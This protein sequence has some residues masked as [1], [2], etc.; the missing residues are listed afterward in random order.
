MKYGASRKVPN[1]AILLLILRAMG[2][3][4]HHGCRVKAVECFKIH[5]L[6]RSVEAVSV[7]LTTL[8][9]Y[10]FSENVEFVEILMAETLV[11]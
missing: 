2:R 7:K 4:A 3:K 11:H 9:V 8:L 6:P 1:R 5:D 10:E